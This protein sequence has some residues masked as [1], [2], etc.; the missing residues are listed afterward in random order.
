MQ[1]MQIQFDLLE[2]VPS[3][4]KPLSRKQICNAMAAILKMI[5]KS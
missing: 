4:T 1:I 3:V 5:I 2:R